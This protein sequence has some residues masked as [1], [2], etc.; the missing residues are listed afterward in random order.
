MLD[1]VFQTFLLLAYFDIALLSIAV[2]N[3]AVSTSY[4]GRETRLS[5]RRMER[6]RQQLLENLR[7]L[8]KEAQVRDVKKE[9]KELE[10]EEKGLGVR[11][12]LLSWWGAVISPGAFFILSFV[13]CVIGMNSD[14]LQTNQPQFLQQQLMIFSSG[15]ISI[16]LMILLFVVRTIDSAAKRIPVPEFEVS[17]AGGTKTLKCKSKAKQE[18]SPRIANKGEDVAEQMH[19]FFCFPPSFEIDEKIG[20]SVFKQTEETDTPDHIA[21]IA[22]TDLLHIDTT[23]YYPISVTVPEEKDSYLIPV[24]IYER[25]T[26]KHKDELKIEVF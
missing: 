18:I 19:I 25:K 15:T 16:G 3:Y 4:L 5:R 2:A 8:K 9:L 26:G 20:Y 21:A 1:S 14:V 13:G 6:K 22:H 23:N 11:I 12:F 17:F 24:R 10:D 7:K